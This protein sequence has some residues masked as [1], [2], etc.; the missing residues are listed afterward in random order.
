MVEVRRSIAVTLIR[1]SLWIRKKKIRQGPTRR[2]NIFSAPRSALMSPWNGFTAISIRAA[3]IRA[4]S[5]G[6]IASRDFLADAPTRTSH[7]AEV[8][9]E[10]DVIAPFEFFFTSPNC[11]KFRFCRHFGGDAPA[12]E[13]HCKGLYSDIRRLPIFPPSGPMHAAPNRRRQNDRVARLP[14]IVLRVAPGNEVSRLA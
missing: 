11:A 8:F 4:R 1:L 14:H 9:I 5:A 10:C 12:R 3:S 7:R 2:R 6:G 13:I